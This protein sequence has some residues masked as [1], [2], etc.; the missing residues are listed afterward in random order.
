MAVTLTLEDEV[1][2]SRGDLLVHSDN[3]PASSDL[4]TA[5][6]VWMSDDP[7]M[8]G[9]Q[10]DFKH[11]G[12]LLSGQVNNIRHKVDVNTLEKLPAPSLAL[13]EIAL[14][15]ISFNQPVSFDA[16][17]RNRGTGAF[18]VIDRLTNVTV[19]AGMI[20]SDGNVIQ[21]HSIN[22]GH[23]TPAERKARYGQQPVTVMFVGLSGAGKSTMA[24][25]LERR[26]FDMGRVSTV[27]D[28][29]TLRLGLSKDLAHDARGRAE[30]L[31][32]SAHFARYLNESGL[33]CCAA[34][35]AA[36]AEARAHAVS[37]IGRENC[38]IVYL[39]PP[40]DVCKQRDPSGIYAADAT[41]PSGNVP[42]VSFPYEAPI[43]ADLMLDT[44]ASSVGECIEQVLGLLK[45]RKLL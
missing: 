25:S 23:V 4:I 35:V 20:E 43:D 21:H 15:D 26:L 42:G 44:S 10:Y 41:L 33:I 14:C 13:N 36:S 24:H 17:R 19:A 38:L 34:F 39:N 3:Q 32:R 29:K 11:A 1:D 9:K 22:Q 45:N 8:P 31:R 27:L 16:Y 12:K 2:I 18:V 28:G 30:N 5:T 40:L 7:M 37:V 6:L